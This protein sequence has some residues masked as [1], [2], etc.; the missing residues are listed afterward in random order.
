MLW[1]RL[2]SGLA[3]LGFAMLCSAP[4]AAANDETI[5]L[6]DYRPSFTVNF[7]DPTQKLLLAEGG[8]FSP[9]YQDWGNL[10]T[11]PGNREEQLYVDPT[12][13]PALTGTDPQGRADAPPGA[14]L[15]PLGI[16]PFHLAPNG[17][18]II[19]EPVPAALR[20]RI[21]RPYVSGM[22]STEQSFQQKY[23]Y[24]E[25]RAQLPRGRGLWPA[26]WL[27]GKTFR[28]HVEI[29][30]V[31]QLG[32]NPWRIYQTSHPPPRLGGG[33]MKTID[34]GFDTSAALHSYGLEWR[35]D[36]LVFTIDRRPT[37]RLDGAPFRDAPPMYLIINLAVGGSWGGNPTPDTA[38][39]ATLR[40]TDIHVYRREE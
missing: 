8:P 25:V 11:L 17:L 30:I 12:F 26:I 35:P 29:D 34:T 20:T 3:P 22:L 2:A 23:G 14:T 7:T 27:V 13:V 24:F 18:S 32:D 10:R 16:N 6:S 9:K 33:V 40:I 4:P 21:D 5:D 36:A 37:A 38:F 39:P 31:E 1:R 28:E 15:T 19:A